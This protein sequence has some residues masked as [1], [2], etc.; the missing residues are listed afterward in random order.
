[1]RELT[2]IGFAPEFLWATC[3]L[4]RSSAPGIVYTGNEAGR[5]DLADRLNFDEVGL[6]MRMSQKATP[7]FDWER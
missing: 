5:F 3:R 1:M 6:V 4:L 7:T 2:G